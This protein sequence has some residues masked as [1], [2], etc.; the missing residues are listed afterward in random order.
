MA[1][2]RLRVFFSAMK[3][4]AEAAYKIDG[5]LEIWGIRELGESWTIYFT[6]PFPRVR[7]VSLCHVRL[8]FSLRLRLSE[9]KRKVHTQQ[10]LR[11]H[12]HHV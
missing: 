3:T 2:R 6:I 5:T 1:G 9:F 10:S 11:Y 4:L 7:L 8:P 12:I